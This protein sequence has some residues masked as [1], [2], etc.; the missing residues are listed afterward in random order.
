MPGARPAPTP[1]AQT[2]VSLGPVLSLV[3]K[4]F[5]EGFL[6]QKT[7]AK[8]RGDHKTSGATL[9]APTQKPHRPGPPHGPVLPAPTLPA[10]AGERARPPGREGRG[11]RQEGAAWGRGCARADGRAAVARGQPSPPQRS[12][13]AGPRGATAASHGLLPACPAEGLPGDSAGSS[14][15]P[16]WADGPRRRRPAERPRAAPQ[17]REAWR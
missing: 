2:A 7:P 1:A 5:I 15:K 10:G 4:F 3:K 14:R 13:D 8:R 12:T 16:R 11:P 9:T 17:A 6:P